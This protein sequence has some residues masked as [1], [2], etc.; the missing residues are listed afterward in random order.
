MSDCFD[1]AVRI[2]VVPVIAIEPVEHAA[3]LADALL[4]GGLP[5]TEITFRTK[6]AAEVLACLHQRRPELLPGAGTLL[7]PEVVRSAVES[8]AAYDPAPGFDPAVA[9]AAQAAGLPIAP[10]IMTPSDLSLATAKG[11]G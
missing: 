6:T 2:G 10:G 9:E 1:L 4:E 8:G 5:T 3:P 7:S 11:S